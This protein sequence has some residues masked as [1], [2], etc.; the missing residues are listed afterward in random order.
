MDISNNLETAKTIFCSFRSN[1][2]IWSMQNHLRQ[3]RLSK[4]KRRSV[5][6]SY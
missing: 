3:R 1:F 4:T 6:T 2:A 5:R